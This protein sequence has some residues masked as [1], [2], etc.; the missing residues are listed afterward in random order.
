MECRS[1]LQH[2][3]ANV[4]PYSV[5]LRLARPRAHA[6][7]ARPD[8]PRRLDDRMFSGDLRLGRP[9]HRCHRLHIRQARVVRLDH[10]ARRPGP[11]HAGQRRDRRCRCRPRVPSADRDP[12]SVS[13]DPGRLR[14]HGPGGLSSRS[15]DGTDRANREVVRPPLVVV[16]VCGSRDHGRANHRKPPRPL[17]HDFDRAAHEL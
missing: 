13:R 8:G 15:M 1:R 10:P 12:L 14:L 3:I 16:R 5:R 17:R 7:P 6:P 9:T 4:G 11:E 2:P